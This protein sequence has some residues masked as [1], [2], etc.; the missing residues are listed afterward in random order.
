MAGTSRVVLPDVSAVLI[1]PVRGADA[2]LLA[3][4]FA[5]LGA[6]SRWMRFLTA[7]NEL[8]PTSTTTTTRRSAR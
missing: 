7:R 3:D 5:W 8:S 6:K 4:G 2:P 1:R